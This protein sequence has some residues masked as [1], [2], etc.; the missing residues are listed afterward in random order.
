MSTLSAGG[1]RPVPLG[2]RVGAAFMAQ[3]TLGKDLWRGLRVVGGITGVL[4]LMDVALGAMSIIAPGLGFKPMLGTQEAGW[5][6]QVAWL[7]CGYAVGLALTSE[8]EEGNARILLEQ[9]PVELGWHFWM[10]TLAGAI[11]SLLFLPLMMAGYAATRLVIPGESLPIRSLV[12]GTFRGMGPWA[13]II[14]PVAACFIGQSWA[15]FMKGNAPLAAALG[16][17]TTVAAYMVYGMSLLLSVSPG[18]NQDFWI[19]AG[20]GLLVLS[21]IELVAASRRWKRPGLDRKGLLE[22]MG[23]HVTVTWSSSP[24]SLGWRIM[25]LPTVV[26]AIAGFLMMAW[27]LTSRS[28]RPLPNEQLL[29]QVGGLLVLVGAVAGAVH[30]AWSLEP[31]EQEGSRFFLFYQ[32]LALRTFY[33]KRI[34]THASLAALVGAIA[35]LPITG[36]VNALDWWVGLGTTALS[37]A[38]AAMF[39]Y[40]CAAGFRIRIVSGGLGGVCA[41]V[42]MMTGHQMIRLLA[43]VEG[44]L[45]HLPVTEWRK[46]HE[47]AAH[48]QVTQGAW[49]LLLTLGLPFLLAFLLHHVARLREQTDSA[50]QGIALLVVVQCILVGPLL[51]ILSPADLWVLLFP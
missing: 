10:K 11:L 30:A 48:L 5:I 24:S 42:V 20:N 17:I 41:L 22:S 28:F 33:L 13:T 50:R 3:G 9:L 19:H 40:T 16:F 37:A 32:P 27:S 2:A 35:A 39:V 6:I 15:V 21:I 46:V 1:L 34:A 43:Q 23:I 51:V 31:D 44:R 4:L 8:E 49:L 18:Q 45:D 25:S 12:E 26:S 47:Y 36:S 14:C 7:V 29:Q 38:C